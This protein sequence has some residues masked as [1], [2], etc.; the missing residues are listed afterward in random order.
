MG[1]SMPIG[2]T[3]PLDFDHLAALTAL[4]QRVEPMWI[5]DPLCWTGIA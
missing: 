2:S 4:A 1:V 5:S 3:D